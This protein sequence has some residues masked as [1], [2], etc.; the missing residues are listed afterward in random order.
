MKKEQF[1][2]LL[3]ELMRVISERSAEGRAKRAAKKARELGA[4]QAG[5]NKDAARGDRIAQNYDAQATGAKSRGDF[6]AGA[7][8]ERSASLTRQ[9]S[10]RDRDYAAD[11]AIST[12]AGRRTLRGYTPGMNLGPRGSIAKGN[13]LPIKLGQRPQE[14]D[15]NYGGMTPD[16]HYATQGAASA[17][18]KA[19]QQGLK[20]IPG[21]FGLYSKSGTAPAEFRSNK[22][23]LVPVKDQEGRLRENKTLLKN[24]IRE[25]MERRLNL[26]KVQAI[27]EKVL[28]EVS[29]EQ[30]NKLSELFTEISMMATQL[31]MT[32]YTKFKMVEWQLSI[33]AVHAKLYEMKEEV[34]KICEKENRVDLMPLVRALEEACQQ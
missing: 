10:Q 11:P 34:M 33:G 5:F 32:P 24:I 20:K 14:R 9:S 21:T 17:A 19:A 26:M 7:S 23:E 27:M 12:R 16:G 22:G 4:G 31:N 30:A 13:A 25:N 2:T 8:A 15:P 3:R 18:E 29:K 1:K 28:P 6:Q